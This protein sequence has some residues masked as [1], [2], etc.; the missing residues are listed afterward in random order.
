MITA[1]SSI[2][3]NDLGVIRA[4]GTYQESITN[5]SG[6]NSSFSL[7]NFATA[8]ISMEDAPTIVSYGNEVVDWR[9]NN[10]T[11][12]LYIKGEVNRY[13][14][15]GVDMDG[16]LSSREV[17]KIFAQ[18]AGGSGQTSKSLRFQ[19]GTCRR[20]GGGTGNNI[21]ISHGTFSG[22]ATTTEYEQHHEFLD[23]ESKEATKPPPQGVNGNHGM[24][25][26]S[27][28]NLVEYCYFHNNNGNGAKFSFG[29]TTGFN[30]VKTPNDNIFRF[31][32]VHSNQLYGLLVYGGKRNFVDLNMVWQNCTLT[33]ALSGIAA[34]SGAEETYIRGNV[35]W[36]N[37][38]AATVNSNIGV[39]ARY[40]SE[41]P[42]P[43]YID[44]NTMFGGNGY[45][46][47]L[48]RDSAEMMGPVHLTNNVMRNAAVADK[49]FLAGLS[50]TTDL[51]NWETIDGDPGFIDEVARNFE[52]QDTSPLIDIGSVQTW[53]LLHDIKRR[54]RTNGL[55]P[56]I[57][58][59][60]LDDSLPGILVVSMPAT[61]A[62]V[63]DVNVPITM[64]VVDSGDRARNAYLRITVGDLTATAIGTTV[65]TGGA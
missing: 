64:S 43:I 12:C 60:E 6:L 36:D 61:H 46:L 17:I 34:W 65:K 21:F 27:A 19:D 9:T 54:N 20:N 1:G 50:L 4:T 41:T 30:G 62:G 38:L 63:K 13:V 40:G 45:N 3:A 14:F 2:A 33:S 23:W 55:G 24:Y 15:S 57:G 44:G 47:S 35:T 53:S 28:F 32:R 10:G 37:G 8:Q 5:L 49:L 58:G 56:D 48:Y 22:T 42:G 59:Y 7:V 52:L 25:V 39:Y 11:A 29:T 51:D 31:C 26:E 16:T 18:S